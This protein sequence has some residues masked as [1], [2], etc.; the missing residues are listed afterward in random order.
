[1][2]RKMRSGW[3]RS[4]KQEKGIALATALICLFVAS[5][6]AAG[7]MY[8]TQ[9]EIWTT[10]SYRSTAQARYIAEAGASQAINWLQNYWTAN[11]STYLTTNA[12]NFCLGVYPVQYRAGGGTCATPPAT[13]ETN[14]V[15]AGSGVTNITDTMS[16]ADATTATDFRS[17]LNNKSITVG[18]V[19]GTF[20]AAVQLLSAYQVNAQW[21]TKWKIISQGT[22]SGARPALVQVVEVVD[23]VV[24]RSSTDAY[25]PS[26]NY[27]IFAT[28]TG[29]NV[30]SMV[31]G[32]HRTDSY[33]SATSGGNVNP[34]LN[35]NGGDVGSMGNLKITN[36]ATIM[37]NYYTP[38]YSTGD[39]GISN[40]AGGGYGASASCGST[41]FG[42]NEDNS[43]S[44]VGC[45]SAGC[46][47]SSSGWYASSYTFHNSLFH[48]RTYVLPSAYTTIPDPV[49]PSVAANTNACNG[50]RNLCNGGS[51]G[52]AGCAVTIPP[53]SNGGSANY[54]QANFG[55]C[56][57]I[58]LQPGVYN[59]D[60]LYISN[61]AQ[62]VLPASGAVTI[63]IL[64]AGGAA[65]PL[66][67]D[68]GTVANNGGNPAN[69]AF[70]YGGSNTINLAA[71]SNMFATVYAPHA[72]V[73]LSGN[74]GLF[75]SVVGHTMSFAGSAHII[76]DNNLRNKSTNIPVGTTT[77]YTVG[78]LHVDEF[79]WSVY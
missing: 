19:T 31:G 44:Q 30:L 72:N 47:D 9:S 17:K 14:Y 74:A 73:T 24:T 28:G 5:T 71:G 54:G 50:F 65:T 27:G 40:S 53:S 20:S 67:V 34:P 11:G 2:T 29:C 35:G 1:M 10:A 36:G 46:P 3:V 13:G 33:N 12:A 52:G 15:F 61:G 60:T 18:S 4:R 23:N 43:G 25:A 66:N 77:T 39:Y 38:Q 69:L 6:L 32:G 58:T 55:S 22:T 48:Q 16:S 49:M 37:G 63:N 51:G 42:V 68:G 45:T 70:V 79:S 41:V 78:Q 26:F 57:V 21:V 7:V 8:S 59:F 76:Y 75:G 62:I 64:N 56:A